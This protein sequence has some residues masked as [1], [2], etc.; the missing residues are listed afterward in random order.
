MI[1]VRA[2]FNVT[3]VGN[4]DAGAADSVPLVYAWDRDGRVKM[5]D[6]YDRFK[7]ISAMSSAKTQ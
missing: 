3:A 4:I 2:Q 6:T 1:G 5:D 7:E